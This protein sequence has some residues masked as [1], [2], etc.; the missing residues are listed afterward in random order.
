MKRLIFVT[1][2]FALL[3]TALPGWAAGLIIVHDSEFWPGPIP[4]PH[5]MPP[6]PIPPWPHPPRPIPPP[7]VYTFAPLEVTY[8]KVNARV[9]DQIAVTSVDQEFYNPNP[10]RLE[11]T[12]I[13]PVPKGAQINKF[14]MEKLLVHRSH[15]DL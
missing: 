14:A 12:F 10:A 13:F 8:A 6:R 3:G 5:P 9:T 15:G 2:L 11:G 4:P 7:R 1:A